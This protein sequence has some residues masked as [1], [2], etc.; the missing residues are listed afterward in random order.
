MSVATPVVVP[1]PVAVITPVVVPVIVKKNCEVLGLV[2]IVL[3]HL[4]LE[5]LKLPLD[6]KL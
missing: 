5:N 2:F 6:Y 4:T 1:A 3:V